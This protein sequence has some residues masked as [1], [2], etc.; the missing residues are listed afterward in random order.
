MESFAHLTPIGHFVSILCLLPMA[1]ED[2]AP[3]S[4]N[5]EYQRCEEKKR[6]KRGGGVL[7]QML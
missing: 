4:T 1:N 6:E 5:D 7:A 3:G 2:E